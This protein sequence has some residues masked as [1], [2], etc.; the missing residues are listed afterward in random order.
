MEERAEV[1]RLRGLVVEDKTQRADLEE[2]FLQAVEDLKKE[3]GGGAAASRRT[4]SS[5]SSSRSNSSRGAG[6]LLAQRSSAEVLDEGSPFSSSLFPEE[7]LM[8]SDFNFRLLRGEGGVPG[9]CF[10]RVTQAAACAVPTRVYYPGF[11]FFS[12]IT[13]IFLSFSYNRIA[14]SFRC[15][16]R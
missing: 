15:R 3:E 16:C 2:F 4:R 11:R 6:A 14:K 5:S 13:L 7:Q 8:M 1:S 9:V 12:A 10:A